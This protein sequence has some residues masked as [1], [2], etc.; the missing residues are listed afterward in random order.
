MG[1]PQLLFIFS[2]FKY[3][4]QKNCYGIRS[5][6]WLLFHKNPVKGGNILEDFMAWFW[7]QIC[8]PMIISKNMLILNYISNKYLGSTKGKLIES[9]KLRFSDNWPT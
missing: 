3:F 4:N 9:N 1:H 2:L 7:D 8:P 5:K 6:V